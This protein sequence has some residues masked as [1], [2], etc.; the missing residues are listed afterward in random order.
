LPAAREAGEA[1]GRIEARSGF[2][3]WF[4]AMNATSSGYLLVFDSIH[5][6]LAAEQAFRARQVWH[7]LVPT[8]RCIRSDCGMVIEFRERDW[9]AVR[10]LLA[11]LAS[12][13]RHVY[14][15]WSGQYR[16]VTIGPR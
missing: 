15:P 6:V 10:E 13:P 16:E 4:P 5:H 11:G 8:P 14:Q 3:L 1:W 7:D 12:P 2:F 9:P